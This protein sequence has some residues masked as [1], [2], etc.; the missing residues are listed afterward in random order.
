MFGVVTFYR[1]TLLELIEEGAGEEYGDRHWKIRFTDAGTEDILLAS[2][3][4]K[5]EGEAFIP[6]VIHKIKIPKN[7]KSSAERQK[8]RNEDLLNVPKHVKHQVKRLIG[9]ISQVCG[10]RLDRL[11]K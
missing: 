2:D 9:K 1:C 7:G 10:H 5:R 4:Y 8:T 6:F 11:P 3:N